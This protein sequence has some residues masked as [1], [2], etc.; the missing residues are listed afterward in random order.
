MT[1]KENDYIKKKKFLQ[2]QY[3]INVFTLV[4][5]RLNVSFIQK[6]VEKLEETKMA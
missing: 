4:I 5:V 3:T 1:K 2:L 6:Y